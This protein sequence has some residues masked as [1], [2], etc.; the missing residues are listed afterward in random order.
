MQTNGRV[1]APQVYRWKYRKVVAAHVCRQNLSAI[2]RATAILRACCAQFPDRM[3]RLHTRT[4][5]LTQGNLDDE[6]LCRSNAC[7]RGRVPV[8]PSAVVPPP[9]VSS[10]GHRRNPR[11]WRSRLTRAPE[12]TGVTLSLRLSPR[13]SG[14]CCRILP[15]GWRLTVVS[16]G[17]AGTMT[18]SFHPRQREVNSSEGRPLIIELCGKF[19]N[20][21][22]R[23]VNIQLRRTYCVACLRQAGSS[24]TC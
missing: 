24:Q 8:R 22:A 15:A 18:A 14:T 1:V 3:R 17:P 11:G 16:R 9:R 23:P 10:A 19:L 7:L 21:P 2:C 4:Y 6:T 13:G 20:E 12:S 5:R